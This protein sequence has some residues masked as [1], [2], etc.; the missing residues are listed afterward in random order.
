MIFVRPAQK[1]DAKIL[2]EWRNDRLARSMSL[3]SDRIGWGDHLTWF[4]ET[5]TD[6]NQLLLI[7]ENVDGTSVGMVRFDV[8]SDKSLVSINLAPL[9]R[10][11]GLGRLCLKVAIKFFRKTYPSVPALYADVLLTNL[12]SR[13]LFKTCGFSVVFKDEELLL[14]KLI[15]NNAHLDNII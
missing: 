7:C 13:F 4:S 12:P 2:Y 15:F 14:L 5:L 1:K 3:S 11:K 9:W 6:L 10:G 8:R